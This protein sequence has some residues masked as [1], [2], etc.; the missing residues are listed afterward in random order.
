[1]ALDCSCRVNES[2]GPCL[3]CLDGIPNCKTLKGGSLILPLPKPCSLAWNTQSVPFEKQSSRAPR[4]SGSL[5]SP[6][7][8][9]GSPA[10][11]V[12]YQSGPAFAVSAWASCWLLAN[13]ALQAP[14]QAIRR[15]VDA[16]ARAHARARASRWPRPAA[17]QDMGLVQPDLG[18]PV[19]QVVS[20]T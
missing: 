17:R 15:Y 16:K 19:G 3:D 5:A 6:W 1:M 12:A 14:A 13:L 8:P 20:N 11:S 2:T 10:R 7:I 9:F 18:G 4:L